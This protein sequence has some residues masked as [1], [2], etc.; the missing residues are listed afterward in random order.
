MI[1]IN[2]LLAPNIQ[3]IL[4]KINRKGF[5]AEESLRSTFFKYHISPL[6]LLELL[7]CRQN[8][9]HT[10]IQNPKLKLVSISPAASEYIST[11]SAKFMQVNAT[12]AVM[13]TINR[14]WINN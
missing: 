12:I 11:N 2:H 6:Q 7:P 10:T 8:A 5:I 9:R 3:K 4:T 13:I 14:I 1:A